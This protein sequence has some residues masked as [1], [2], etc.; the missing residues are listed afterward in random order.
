MKYAAIAFVLLLAACGAD[1]V[2][3]AP[4]SPAQGVSMSGEVKIGVRT[5]L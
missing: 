1:G 3:T 2:P 5:T 4:D